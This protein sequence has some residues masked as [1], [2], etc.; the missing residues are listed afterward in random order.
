MTLGIH[1]ANPLAFLQARSRAGKVAVNDASSDDSEPEPADA[2]A[3]AGSVEPVRQ[4]LGGTS[5]LDRLRANKAKA[6]ASRS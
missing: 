5:Q 3:G 2:P 4:P 1:M 6:A